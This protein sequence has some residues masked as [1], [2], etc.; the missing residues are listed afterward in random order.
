M[1]LKTKIELVKKTLK[2]SENCST[3]ELVNFASICEY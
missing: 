1:G 3:V 2:I